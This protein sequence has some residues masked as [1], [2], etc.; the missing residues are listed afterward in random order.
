LGHSRALVD[1]RLQHLRLSVVILRI[2]R[3]E[4]RILP[5]QLREQLFELVD[6]VLVVCHFDYLIRANRSLEWLL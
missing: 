4:L 6:V 2:G 1:R 3:E 5:F